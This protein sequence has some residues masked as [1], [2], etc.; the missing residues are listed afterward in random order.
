MAP[1]PPLS[2]GRNSPIELHPATRS[3][4]ATTTLVRPARI[5]STSQAVPMALLFPTDDLQHL[6]L[7]RRQ[8]MLG[9]L[10]IDHIVLCPPAKATQTE[11]FLA[12]VR[13]AVQEFEPLASNQQQSDDVA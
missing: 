8:L 1:M 6:F 11:D 4:A 3:K 10:G 2:F 7:D 9:Q 12:V 13:A 5:R